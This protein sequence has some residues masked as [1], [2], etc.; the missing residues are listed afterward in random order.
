[1]YFLR[2]HFLRFNNL[3]TIDV[4]HIYALG[5]NRTH[6]A[7]FGGLRVIRY[8]TRTKYFYRTI[9]NYKSNN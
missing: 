6:I 5:G 7:S 4:Q 9:N 2:S 8:T 3:I 1:M